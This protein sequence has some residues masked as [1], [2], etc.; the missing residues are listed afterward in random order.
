MF[1]EYKCY[2]INMTFPYMTITY[3]I[4]IQN[5]SHQTLNLSLLFWKIAKIDYYI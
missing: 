3:E 1:S 5:L 2:I 4:K